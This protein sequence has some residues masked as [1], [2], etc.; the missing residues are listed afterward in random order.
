M[1]P[2]GMVPVHTVAGL[3]K[4]G[5]WLDNAGIQQEGAAPVPRVSGLI[6]LG[7]WS[8]NAGTLG[9]AGTAPVDADSATAGVGISTAAGSGSLGAV[10]FVLS[11]SLSSAACCLSDN[12]ALPFFLSSACGLLVSTL[13]EASF[14][15]F[16]E[17][18]VADV[19]RL[20]FRPKSSISSSSEFQSECCVS[21]AGGM[22]SMPGITRGGT[23]MGTLPIVLAL[24]G[25]L[26]GGARAATALASR[27]LCCIQKC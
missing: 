21:R 10:F 27:R 5:P 2:E 19:L 6:R 26:A 12:F 24:A 20:F 3:I 23:T 4:L 1:Q 15:A 11:L 8:D 13:S 14:R 22:T 16:C 17:D 25:M 9:V 7:P 18:E